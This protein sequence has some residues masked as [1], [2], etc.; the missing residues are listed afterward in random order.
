[1]SLMLPIP[2]D[3]SDFF[4]LLCRPSGSKRQ[5]VDDGYIGATLSKCQ[6]KHTVDV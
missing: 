6:S 4:G 1:M 3:S 2:V 5:F